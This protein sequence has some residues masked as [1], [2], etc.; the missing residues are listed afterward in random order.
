[1]STATCAHDQ[2][3]KRSVFVFL[4]AKALERNTRRAFLPKLLG[5]LGMR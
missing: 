3:R 2:E 5:E 4:V 1:M